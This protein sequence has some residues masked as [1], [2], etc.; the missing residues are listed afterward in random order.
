MNELIFFSQIFCIA[1]G[2]LLA[3][4]WGKL[5]L[6]TLSAFLAV[7][8]NVFVM[9][10]ITLFQLNVT[11]SDALAVGSVLSVGILQEYYGSQSAK[12]AVTISFGLLFFF[13]LISQIHL[14]YVPSSFDS[15]HQA[16]TSILGA[17][18]RIVFASFIAFYIMQKTNLGVLKILQDRFSSINA[19]VRIGI[20]TIAAQV[21]DTCIFGYLGLY[22]IVHSISHV[23]LMS[24]LVKFISILISVPFTAFAQRFFKEEKA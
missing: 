22:G 13:G 7:I 19:S 18:P 10:Q 16:F 24:L 20:A 2:L 12:K 4:R 5:A 1:L 21:V 8:S 23:I 15:T 17:T 3:L 11:T 14:K 9:K 6:V